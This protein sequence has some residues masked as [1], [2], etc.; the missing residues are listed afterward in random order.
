MCRIPSSI[1]TLWLLGM[2]GLIPG[3]QMSQSP[4]PS[5]PAAET[6]PVTAVPSLDPA[7]PPPGPVPE[8]PADLAQPL[9]LQEETVVVRQD[10]AVGALKEEIGTN[11]LTVRAARFSSPDSPEMEYV[12]I[13]DL[14]PLSEAFLSPEQAENLGKAL[15]FLC[16]AQPPAGPFQGFRSTYRSASDL[17]VT[18]ANAQDGP[19]QRARTCRIEIASGSFVTTTNGLQTLKSLLQ[20]ATKKLKEAQK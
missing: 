17:T 4:E 10:T 18:C 7:P 11:T 19:D 16:A 3:C 2:V 20:Q 5:S 15:D 8:T 12:V 14:N 9:H 6:G 13:V 1:L